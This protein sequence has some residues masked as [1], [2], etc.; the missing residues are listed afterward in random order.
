M[1]KTSEDV[2]EWGRIVNGKFVFGFNI[3]GTKSNPLFTYIQYV[4]MAF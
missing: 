3:A 4:C 1:S 2:C